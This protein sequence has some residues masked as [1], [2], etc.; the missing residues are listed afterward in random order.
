ME[1]T[2]TRVRSDWRY[3]RILMRRAEVA[4][5]DDDIETLREIALDLSSSASVLN[6]YLDERGVEL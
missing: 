1:F 3:A 5:R 2:K 6:G 4:L